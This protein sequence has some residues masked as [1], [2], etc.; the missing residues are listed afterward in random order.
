MLPEPVVNFASCPTP[1]SVMLPEPVAATE[2]A[3]GRRLD[4]VA[5]ADVVQVLLL[6][7]LAD[8]NHVS[9]LLDGRIG[10]NLLRLRRVAVV[11]HL[12]D[13]VNM[14]LVGGSARDREWMPDAGD[15]R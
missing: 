9:L 6:A 10:G 1:V 2:S 7:V 11:I 5:D 4:F 15:N 14:D 8:A 13:A 3:V 12:D